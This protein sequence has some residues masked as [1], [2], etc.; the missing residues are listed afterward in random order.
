MRYFIELSYDG[1]AYHGWQ[2]QEGAAGIQAVL[3]TAL[4]YKAGLHEGI[5]GCGRTDTGVHARQFFAHFDLH[6]NL[7]PAQLEQLTPALNSFLPDDIAVHRIFRVNDDAHAR[8]GATLR[9][10]KYYINILPDPFSRHYAWYFHAPLNVDAMNEAAGILMGYDDFTSFAKLHGGNK[11]NICHVSHA[12]WQQHGRQLEF[13]ITADRFLRNMVRAVVGTLVNIGRGKMSPAEMHRII[14]QKNRGSAG[15]SVPACG[16]FL[17][18]I[19][20]DW[21]SIL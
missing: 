16:L 1:T 19:T 8:F 11:T 13:T 2:R 5:T 21:E 3:E 15:M 14:N 12:R 4:Q 18:A 20:Y 17:H 6:R 7:A 10:Y 9:T